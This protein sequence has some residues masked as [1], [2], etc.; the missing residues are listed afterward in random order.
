MAEDWWK[1]LDPDLWEP[2]TQ[3]APAVREL[4]AATLGALLL[5][6]TRMPMST[7]VDVRTLLAEVGYHDAVSN[8][9]LDDALK[10]LIDTGHVEP[11]EDY[12]AVVSSYTDAKRRREAWALT[13]QA[14][15]MVT[16]VRD[17]IDNLDR[18]L[19]L[20][21]RLL[22]AV[23]DTIRRTLDHF[24][25]DADLLATD[26]A[27]VKAHVEQLQEASGDFYGAVASLV[28]HDVTDDTVFTT[29]RER[30]LLALRHFANQ[31]QRALERVRAAITELKA[32]GASSIV[33]RALPGAGVLDEQA[34]Q[35]WLSEK[36]QQLD[37]LE[38]WF[39]PQG[40]IERL[41]DASAGAIQ[42]LLGAIERRFY[43]NAR[44][45][46]MGADFRQLARMIHTQPSENAAYQVFAA[47]FGIWTA[48]HPR[49]PEFEDISPG[50]TAAEGTPHSA[51]AVLRTTE[52]GARSAGRP[53]KIPDL[54]E[55][56]AKAELASKVELERRS[57]LAQDLIT[58]GRVP[59]S[60]F[61][62]LDADHTAVFVSLLEEALG[63]FTR[64][65]GRG[66]AD[67]VGA[68]MLVWVGEFGRMITVELEEGRLTAPDLRVEVISL[69][70]A[71]I[72]S[73]EVA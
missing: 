4:R 44:G 5:A 27:Q 17:V 56:R 24:H 20:P 69:D 33:E 71:A 49:R 70:S 48:R 60:H 13:K 47:G 2:L 53:Q 63:A 1:R 30:I 6:S 46:D 62:G 54:A 66:T 31:T 58:P 67:T 25:R 68:R 9:D 43:A 50:L 37:G 45:S 14:R 29:S 40:S 8:E 7:L 10:A 34:Q 41:I 64:T 38:A 32:V 51:E 15:I 26:L 22:D 3:R 59:L 36:R 28:Q 18:S 16:A 72:V 55:T 42:T 57:A 61:A 12:T 19:Q 39:A 11:F 21:P 73:T 52:R 35:S 65:A 23:E